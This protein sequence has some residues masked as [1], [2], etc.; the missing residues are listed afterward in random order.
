MYGYAGTMKAKPGKRDEVVEILLSGT[1]GLREHGCIL[2]V[3][4]NSG[5]DDDTICVTEVW[6]TKEHHDASL[7]LPE[8]KDAIGR[9]MP[10]LTGEFTSQEMTVVGGLGVS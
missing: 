10:M 6:Q 1:E 3:V 2:Y 5:A 9:A 7:Q 8:T 4:S